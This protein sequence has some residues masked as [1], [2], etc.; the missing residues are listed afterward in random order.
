MSSIGLISENDNSTV[1]AE[2][3]G[4]NRV[5]KYF[6]SEES[7]ENELIKTLVEQGYE[8]LNI[9]SEDE[10]ISNLRVQLEKLNNYHFTDR[11]WDSFFTKIIA[12]FAPRIFL[13]AI[14]LNGWRVAAVAATPI[15]SPIIDK[16]KNTTI[17]TIA[18]IKFGVDNVISLNIPN[19]K[20]KTNAIAK[21]IS[22]HFHQIE[23]LDCFDFGFFSLFKSF[24]EIVSEFNQHQYGSHYYP[25]VLCKLG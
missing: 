23:N 4:L 16:I 19:V 6:Q 25:Q 12:S 13:D 2:Y 11:E 22:G 10:L 8:R 15:I 14:A 9:N 3:T 20:D 18:K 24:V 17:T 1:L 7:L 21:T 5:E